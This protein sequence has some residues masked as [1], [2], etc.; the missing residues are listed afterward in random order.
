MLDL[1]GNSELD[2]LPPFSSTDKVSESTLNTQLTGQKM[3]LKK[4]K[5]KNICRKG[6]Y[7]NV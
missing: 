6:S 4:I 1:L 3:K 2:A 5:I 7:K